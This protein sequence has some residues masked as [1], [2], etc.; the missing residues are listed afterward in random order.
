MMS[1]QLKVLLTLVMITAIISAILVVTV[2]AQQPTKVWVDDDFGPG[3]PG[4]GVTHFK[5]IQDGID[6][7]AEGGI[8]HVASG[9]YNEQLEITKSLTLQAAAGETVI[10]MPPEAL[11]TYEVTY[12]VLGGTKTRTFAP[13]IIVRPPVSASSVVIE[14]FIIDGNYELLDRGYVGTED[15]IYV[16]V[17]YV[18]FDGAIRNCEIRNFRPRPEQTDLFNNG[19]AIWVVGYS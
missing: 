8:V 1:H 5:S 12:D 7:V 9:T 2:S 15:P 4:W 3:T 11:T 13:L 14:G 10:I 19:F 17:V 16:G 6:A 18:N